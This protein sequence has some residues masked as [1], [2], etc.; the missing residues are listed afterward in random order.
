MN[1]KRFVAM[2]FSALFLL[3]VC[4]ACHTENAAEVIPLTSEEKDILSQMGEDI[5]VVSDE[6]FPQIVPEIIAHCADYTGQVYQMEGFYTVENVNGEESPYFYRTLVNNGEK[7]ICELPMK[8]LEKE[9]PL[10]AWVRV[11]AIINFSDLGGEEFATLEVVAVESLAMP[12][13]T[14]LPWNGPSHEH[15]H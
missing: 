8:Y 5:H 15:E 12:K 10:G 13:K 1:G 11:T 7:T 2:L 3:L 6:D 14:E 9:L 4:T